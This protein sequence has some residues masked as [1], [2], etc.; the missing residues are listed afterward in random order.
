MSN[1]PVCWWLCVAPSVGLSYYII[2]SYFWYCSHHR[3]WGLS[4]R[5]GTESDTKHGRSAIKEL[6]VFI[7]KSR[8]IQPYGCGDSTP[9]LTV[10]SEISPPFCIAWSQIFNGCSAMPIYAFP[11][12]WSEDWIPANGRR[13]WHIHSIRR[14][15]SITVYCVCSVDAFD[16]KF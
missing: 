2:I 16:S 15:D 12:S 7:Y 6:V 4:K 13:A 9:S 11:Q 8:H 14:R 1:H 5:V 10:K 3:S